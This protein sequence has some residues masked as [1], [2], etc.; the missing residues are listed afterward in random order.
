MTKKSY[1]PFWQE[2]IHDITLEQLEDVFVRPFE[3]KQK[4]VYL[5]NRLRTFLDVLSNFGITM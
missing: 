3:N 1:P 2:G 5:C 4:R